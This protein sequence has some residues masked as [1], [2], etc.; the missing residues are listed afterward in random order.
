VVKRILVVDDDPVFL[1]PA[2]AALEC[3]GHVVT[4]APSI[5]AARGHINDEAFDLIVLDVHFRDGTGISLLPMIRSSASNAN[6][7]VLMVSADASK[8]L[9][10]EARRAGAD[11]YLVKPFS[12]DHFYR[13]VDALLN[14]A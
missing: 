4:H 9:A 12:L 8:S 5:D 7:P 6:T 14:A 2:G 13:R 1:M 10:D 11:G 3:H